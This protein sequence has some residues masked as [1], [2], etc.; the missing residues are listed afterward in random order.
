VGVALGTL[1]GVST[2][3][4]L[5]EGGVKGISAVSGGEGSGVG[6]FLGGEGIVGGN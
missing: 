4:G 1:A 2:G 6:G 3:C 5:L